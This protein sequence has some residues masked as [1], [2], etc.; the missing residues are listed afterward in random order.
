[1]KTDIFFCPLCRDTW[2]CAVNAKQLC[3]DCTLQGSMDCIRTNSGLIKQ[4]VVAV[5]NECSGD[6]PKPEQIAL[7]KRW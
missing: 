3:E 1:M 7:F 4:F 6:R 2:A 5:C